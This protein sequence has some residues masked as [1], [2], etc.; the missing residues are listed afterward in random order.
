MQPHFT[1]EKGSFMLVSK[2]LESSKN[3]KEAILTFKTAS[4]K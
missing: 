1:Q 3:K 2:V 4:L